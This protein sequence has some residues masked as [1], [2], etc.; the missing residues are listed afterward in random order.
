M[1]RRF[2]PQTVHDVGLAIARNTMQHA[3]TIRWCVLSLVANKRLAT[4]TPASKEYTYLHMR[5]FGIYY[6]PV[7]AVRLTLITQ[8][9]LMK[10]NLIFFDRASHYRII[11]ST[12]F[13]AQFSLFINNMFVTLLSSTCFEH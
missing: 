8:S 12:N 6:K 4:S 3:V 11:S 7:L 9:F 5:F 13:N 1:A 2:Q 10:P